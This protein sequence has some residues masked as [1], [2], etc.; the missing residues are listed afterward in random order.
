MPEDTG[1]ALSDS[2]CLP[3]AEGN[4]KDLEPLESDSLVYMSDDGTSVQLCASTSGDIPRQGPRGASG[5][6]NHEDNGILD[7]GPDVCHFLPL[8]MTQATACLGD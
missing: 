4:T 8:F 5:K 6:T 2:M 7:G 1:V 3:H